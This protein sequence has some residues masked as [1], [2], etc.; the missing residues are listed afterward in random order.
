MDDVDDEDPAKAAVELLGGI[1]GILMS[2][3]GHVESIDLYLG[4]D[5]GEAEADT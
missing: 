3:D 5:D 2:I 4:G 1:A